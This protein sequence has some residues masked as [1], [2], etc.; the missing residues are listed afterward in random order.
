[1]RQTASPAGTDAVGGGSAL[2]VTGLRK[3]FAL[4]TGGRLV[5]LDDIS[6]DASPGEFVA[7]VGPSGCGKTTLLKIL[8]GRLEPSAGDVSVHG[9]HLDRKKVG[10]VFQE[11][12]L[13]PWRSVRDNAVFGVDLYVRRGRR[14]LLRAR[15]SELLE[16]VGLAGFQTY[17]PSEI[18][19]GMQQ[20]TNLV[21]ALAIAPEF[22][23]MDEPFG[24]LDAQ[25]R[26]G[27]QTELQHIAI[28]AQCTIV[29]VTHDIREAIYLADR[30]LIL[31]KQPT[32]IARTIEI[33]TPRPRDL[34]YQTS[35]EFNE[36][37][38]EA[39]ST[40]RGL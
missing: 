10:V 32:R 24:S 15:T 2:S 18:S 28:E 39:W 14:N 40:L 33:P 3:E 25:T 36:L 4:R 19:G 17:F 13:F 12:S 16:K 34:P 6:F 5:V 27:L 38:R 26:E 8:S 22:L 21:R 11:A 35:T 29:F 23:L 30:V 37:T 31:S 9:G 7:V 1:M 20:R